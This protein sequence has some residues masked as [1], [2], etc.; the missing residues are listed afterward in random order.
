MRI[1]DIVSIDYLLPGMNRIELMEKI[2][3]YNQD[4]H[5]YHGIGPG[6]TGCSNRN[7]SKGAVDYI[8]KND[9]ALNLEN[10]V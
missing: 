9:N 1:P 4:I 6:E 5:L 3:N 2:K 7:L 8:I 10:S